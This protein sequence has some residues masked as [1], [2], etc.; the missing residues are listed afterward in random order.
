[1]VARTVSP[2]PGNCG[3]L[4]PQSPP[5][6]FRNY[7]HTRT[8]RYILVRAWI[9][10]RTGHYRISA[11]ELL[12]VTW[13]GGRANAVCNIHNVA[14]NMFQHK[15]C[16][17]P[18]PTTTFFFSRIFFFSKSVQCIAYF[19][20]K[21]RSC[22]LTENISMTWVDLFSS[23]LFKAFYVCYRVMFRELFR[24]AVKLLSY[25]GCRTVM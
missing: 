25:R 3:S 17:K 9:L 12:G 21:S 5:L 6:V 10:Q 1:M 4:R 8:Y 19:I 7:R 23:H 22:G 24:L 14:G 16:I 20:F 15:L 11:V 13:T 18:K 2:G